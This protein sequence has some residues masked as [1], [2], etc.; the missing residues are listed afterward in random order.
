[1]IYPDTTLDNIQLNPSASPAT[2]AVIWLH[3]LGAN[4][5]DFVP[6]VRELN[7][8]H[9]FP[10]R[11]I[12]PHAP[13]RPVTINQGYVMPAWYDIISPHIDQHA[14]EAGMLESIAAIN[15]L[16]EQQEK[17]G[18]PRNKIILAGF[19][20]GAVIALRAGLS[21]QRPLGGIIALSG[22]LPDA[23]NWLKNLSEP[24]AK[25]PVFSRMADKIILCPLS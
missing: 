2:G 22:Y 11:F 19:S 10:L 5:E 18:I 16:I 21:C 12:F 1:M 13:E 23:A 25:T 17:S 7:Q 8:I 20:Q 9:P 4:G 24:K 6:I 14:D 3:G 15:Q